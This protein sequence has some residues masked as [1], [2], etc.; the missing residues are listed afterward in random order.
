MTVLDRVK[1]EIRGVLNKP[2]LEI[3]DAADLVTDL[4]L[5]SIDVV[6]LVTALDTIY[7]LDPSGWEPFFH[8]VTTNAIISGH[9]TLTPAVIAAFVTRLIDDDCA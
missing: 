5:D 1:D 6:E 9:W 8:A 4:A 3:A 2:R 7:D